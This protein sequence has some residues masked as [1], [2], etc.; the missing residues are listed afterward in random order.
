MINNNHKTILYICNKGGHYS[1]MLRLKGVMS[2]FNSYIISDKKEAD[3]DWEGSGNAIYIDAYN[4]KK[5]RLF[6]FFKNLWQCF[7]ICIKYKPEYNRSRSRHT[8]VYSRTY[9][10]KETYIY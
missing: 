6:H 8:N 1:Q 7:R 3:K 10:G 4:V 2:K 5:H 9:P